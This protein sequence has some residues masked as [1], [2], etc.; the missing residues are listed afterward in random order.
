MDFFSMPEIIWEAVALT[1][2]PQLGAMATCPLSYDYL[3]STWL[4]VSKL[5]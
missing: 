5:F 2:L 4:P 3:D 1:L